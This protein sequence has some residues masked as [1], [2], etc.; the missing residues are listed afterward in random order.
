MEPTTDIKRQMVNE[1]F[2]R[3]AGMG[4]SSAGISAPVANTPSPA[5]PI[6]TTDM[7]NPPTPS[8]GAA[9]NPSDG[10]ISAMKQQK[11]EAEKLSDAMVWRMKKLT[12][13][14]Q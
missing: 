14:G 11:G 2:R 3:R 9:G 4:G 10:T 7:T 13:R 12:E 5:N 8:G 1:E 6:P